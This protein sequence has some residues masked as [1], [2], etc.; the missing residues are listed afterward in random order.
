MIR[1]LGFLC[2]GLLALFST[3][4]LA[5]TIDTT[6]RTEVADAYNN[7]Y[8]AARSV[9]SGWNGDIGICDAGTTSLDH[10][11]ATINTANFYRALA[12]LPPV[13]LISD[14]P[15]DSSSIPVVVN[16]ADIVNRAREAALIA[17]AN[18]PN[19]F[20]HYPENSY[21]C[22]TLE[23]HQGAA[24]SNLSLGWGGPGSASAVTGPGAIDSYIND[25]GDLSTN[26]GNED[27]GHRRWIL[28]S[29]QVGLATGDI[30]NPTGQSANA[31]RV[32]PARNPPPTTPPSPG[33]GLVEQSSLFAANAPVSGANWIAWP[34][35]GFIPYELIPS[36]GRWS[37]SYPSA[38]FN[39]ATVTMTDSS[40]SLVAL[41]VEDISVAPGFI[42]GDNTLRFEPSGLPNFNAGMADTSY[43]IEVSGV[44]GAG[45][46]S[47][48]CYTVTVFDP[49]QSG[50]PSAPDLCNTSQTITFNSMVPSPIAG[51]T[52][53]VSA[54]ASSG[55]PVAFSIDQAS[56]SICTISAARVTFTGVGACIVN[57]NQ[58]GDA[59]YSPAPQVQQTI[60]VAAGVTGTNI[61]DLSD[62]T[63]PSTGTGWTWTHSNGL[64]TILN[65]ADVT[66]INS[67]NRRLEVE[68]GAEATITLDN[69]SVTGL[70]INVSALRLNS[71]ANVM[72]IL[73]DGSINT[74]TAYNNSAGIFTTNATLTI[75]SA[76]DSSI[77]NATGSGNGAGIGGTYNDA[78]GNITINGGTVIATSANDGA[79][80][81]GGRRGAGGNIVISGGTVI[82]TSTNGGA[83][84]GGGQQ[85]AGGNIVI[86]GGTVIATST[87]DGAGIGGGQ[88]GAGGNIVISG[89]TVNATGGNADAGIGGG[90]SS[91]ATGGPSG[92]I[93]IYGEDTIVTAKGGSGAQD[94][95]A[96][97]NSGGV[98]G[99]T[100]NIFVALPQGN[101]LGTGDAEIGNPVLFTATPETLTGV[102]AVTLPAPFDAA[103]FTVG[104]EYDL[105]TG[106][107]S[108]LEEKTFSVLTTFTT[109]S[110]GFALD[111]YYATPASIT[112]NALMA[113]NAQ[114]DFNKT[115]T[116]NTQ[117]QSATFT[118]GQIGVQNLTIAATVSPSGTPE[119]QWYSNTSASNAGGS[120][121]TGETNTSFT[122]PTDLTVAGSPYYYYCVVTVDGEVDTPSNVATVTVIPVVHAQ[123]P[124][125]SAQPQAATYDLNAPA[126]ALS[127]TA[128]VTD[129]GTLSY[130]WY[131]NTTN[132]TTG[133]T[134]VGTNNSYTPPT[135]TAGTLYYYV[136]V[137]NTNTAP[138]VTGN[139]TA[140]TQSNIVGVT[141]E[142]HAATPTIN[143]QPVG[144]TYA[145]NASASA[146]TVAASVTDGGALSYQWYS[147]TTNS[148][149]GATPVGTDSDSYA[150]PTTTAGTLYYYVVVTNTN[151]SVNGTQTASTT[152][153]VVMVR[154]YTPGTNV[155]DLSDT[156][157][158]LTGDGWTYSGGTD[159]VYTILDSADVTVTNSN[160]GSQRR[161]EVDADAEAT[162]TLNNA[163][164]TDLGA[165]Q[166]ALLLNAGADVMLIL[167]D[168]STNTLTGFG[169]AAGIQTTGATLTI[170][171]EANGTG[172]LNAS[173]P[174][175]A[176]GG[177]WYGD[178]GNITISGGTV[179]ASCTGSGYASGTAIGNGPYG[180]GGNITIT[181]GTVNATSSG[182]VGSI[183]GGFDAG[184]NI[185]ISGGTVN[186]TYSGSI[187]SAIGGG[188]GGNITIS[189]GTINAII[190]N[191]GAGAGIGGDAYDASGSIL[192]YGEDTIVTAKGGSGA[193]DIGAGAS[194]T[195]DSVFVALPQ[196]N[197]LGTSDAEIGDPVLFTA[198][199]ATTTGVVAV[200]LPS[201]FDA[202]PFN[203]VDAT[204]DL[205]TGLDS[206][207]KTLSV[208]TTLG[209]SDNIAFTLAGYNV[210]PDPATG[211]YL[212]SPNAQV[213]FTVPAATVTAIAIKEQPTTLSYTVGNA[214]DLSA[215]EVTLTY[216]DS[217]TQDVTFTDFGV[218]NITTTPANGTT[219][220]LP[221]NGTSVTV[222]YDSSATIQATTNSLTVSAAPAAPIITSASN[223]TAVSG[224]GGTFQVT[225]TGTATINY[226][227]SGEP[228]GVSINSSSGLITIAG[229][230]VAGTHIFAIT[231]SNNVPPDAT[232][233]F[234]LTV[235]AA[236][237]PPVI[238]TSPGAL[239]NG[240]VGTSYSV[241]LAA[242]NNPT[243]WAVSVG[244]L[245]AGLSLGNNG[246]ISGTPT[247]A[248]T[249]NFS[250][251][252]TN[253]DGTSAAV[254]FS[255]T[256]NVALP[257]ITTTQ[258]VIASGRINN[259]YSL[260][261]A[262]TG[263]APFTWAI[264]GGALPPGLT[265]D[266]NTG[267]I[268][269]TPTATGVFNFEVTIT[270]SAATSSA[271]ALFSITILAPFAAGTMPIPTLSPVGLVL[272]A[273]ALG[274]ATFRRRVGKA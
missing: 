10:Q 111:G 167:A 116:I 107:G 90:G 137:T 255:I 88:Q 4:L 256:V 207:G 272:L 187:G 239:A 229:T 37:I 100:G 150:P 240:T 33:G 219:L 238:T 83:G 112:G 214:L 126:T 120:L 227:L 213:D 158:P 13:H 108:G 188:D 56:A 105:M 251:T 263:S 173:S 262:A 152:S 129:N 265:L 237:A 217:S 20:T 2:T 32:L 264:T 136:V 76:D 69:A 249:A 163:S 49:S 22:Y 189:G 75:N 17:S 96:G 174:G 169:T 260:Q 23:G 220:A 11:K 29:H 24:A 121:L 1:R 21:T 274:V 132:S 38:D 106:L 147:N 230:T 70:V 25:R 200:T 115:I 244:S 40:G 186:S 271:P 175:T 225:A 118:V 127:V 133:A 206:T 192:I 94:I 60:M 18:P 197:L 161:L 81:G 146:L 202:A 191:N 64:Y 245:P 143:T 39:A 52:Y 84:I 246:V 51:S 72:L 43:K 211:D 182:N 9:S 243:S 168:G 110:I 215:L 135:T 151:N 119:Y 258:A 266:T 103:P 128:S 208:I 74:L 102:V 166:S 46:P 57:A 66:V 41:S 205:L 159:G 269:G 68:A 113:G 218:Y 62:A 164:I 141:V 199:P 131:S 67:G 261:L 242:T 209:A 145:L 181:G 34:N 253:G 259:P 204:Y 228:A 254:A 142:V 139:T 268:S 36:S 194:G 87:N 185:T 3:N 28:Y 138:I 247:T 42:L 7:I 184:A 224:T 47:S 89:G 270:D 221:H 248:E 193:Q 210:A 98:Q 85:A 55:L 236:A 183:G 154:V 201:P 226:S 222:I 78:G 223:A 27:L 140:T 235:T 267:L 35:P 91:G 157:P 109:Q 234:T 122:I 8:L 86:S 80:I 5:Y 144:A 117:P 195:V 71:G 153:N 216:S 26:I 257:V 160:T 177:G 16:N 123:A 58:A 50:S 114:I 172:I 93:L 231:A 180:D 252:A 250:V 156:D 95:G 134:Q 241:A 104:G 125:I 171:G 44:S 92:N 15:A 79:G 162:I 30:F 233:S 130:Q 176:I 165:G 73:A 99:A 54:T 53:T 45:I 59:T 65:G 48:Y 170:D 212:Q 179:N 97:V 12:G 124:N 273:L 6:S 196:G 61:I 14:S 77:L 82:A 203:D 19:E 198:T 232:Q 63:P 31:L 190:S 101:L 155:I 149:T 148:T 178:G